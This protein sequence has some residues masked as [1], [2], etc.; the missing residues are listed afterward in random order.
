MESKDT[1]WCGQI[2]CLVGSQEF[3]LPTKWWR[4]ILG[5]FTAPHVLVELQ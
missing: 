3:Q 5:F 2:D 1:C 4:E